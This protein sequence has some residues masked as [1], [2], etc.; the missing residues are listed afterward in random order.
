MS[1]IMRRLQSC[2]VIWINIIIISC[3][4]LNKF[5]YTLASQIKLDIFRELQLFVANSLQSYQWTAATFCFVT[6]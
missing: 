1:I 4:Y 3:N 5:A 6:C 2:N